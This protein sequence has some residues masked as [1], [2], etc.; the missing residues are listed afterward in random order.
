MEVVYCEWL[1]RVIQN[2]EHSFANTERESTHSTTDPMLVNR[3][4]CWLLAAVCC[5][6]S[7]VC[8]LAGWLENPIHDPSKIPDQQLL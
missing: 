2:S 7:A 6:L 4:I 8:C 5:L 1:D 3:I